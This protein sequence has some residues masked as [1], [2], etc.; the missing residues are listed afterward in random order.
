MR[1]TNILLIIILFLQSFA[2]HAERVDD[3]YQAEITVPNESEEVKQSALRS[4]MAIVLVKLTGD[5]QSVNRQEFR[6]MLNQAENYTRQYGY[7][8]S[9]DSSGQQRLKFVVQF[10]ENLINTAFRERSLVAWGK[11]RPSVLLWLAETGFGDD[12]LLGQENNRQPLDIMQQRSQRR[13]LGMIF[14][15]L[16]LCK[17]NESKFSPC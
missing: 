7:K 5:R 4:A 15:L 16:D 3:L 17:L 12:K 13:G 2:V 11:E 10:E 8:Q 14:P 1:R 6:E 9:T